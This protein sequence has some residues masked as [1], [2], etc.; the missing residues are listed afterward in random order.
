MPE[1]DS[2]HRAA[3][4]LQALVGRRVEVETPHPRAAALGLAERL[5]GRR[6]ESVEAI[7]KNLVLTFEGG[8]V[9][10]SHLRMSGRWQVRP[11]DSRPPPGLPWLVL[12]GATHE[13]VL[14]NGPVLEL[15]GRALRR[16]G[17]DILGDPPDLERMVEYL[18]SE[19]PGRE[20]GDA[21]LD[22]RL[23]AGIGN[24]WRSEALWQARISPW[25]RL[26]D[27]SDVELED[28]LAEAARLMRAS[29]DGNVA[30]RAVPTVA[31]RLEERGR[32]LRTALGTEPRTA[33]GSSSG[34]AVYR[35]A[36][37]PCPRCGVPIRSRGQG[38]DN[39]TAYW[40]PDCQRGEVPPGA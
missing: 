6:L 4:R 14:W 22:Q 10:R 21:L 33:A 39:R 36:G 16:L 9:L 26:A 35:R 3:R 28:V 38:D 32:S 12:R 23:V 19:H 13:A 25:R 1:G 5:D 8:P 27:L 31:G 29:L 7:G 24:L 34:R 37:R 2:L 20:I 30:E 11:R 40:C 15:T 17:P 18:R